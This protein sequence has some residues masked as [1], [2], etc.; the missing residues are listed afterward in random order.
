MNF[1]NQIK[2]NLSSIEYD[3]V[4]YRA[5]FNTINKI[6]IKW[7]LTNIPYISISNW[8]EIFKNKLIKSL[9]LK[10]FNN[11]DIIVHLFIEHLKE[12]NSDNIKIFK[13]VFNTLS[14]YNHLEKQLD[15][16]MKNI[17][18]LKSL[19]SICQ[20]EYEKD[21][22]IRDE[23]I[24]KIILDKKI[25]NITTN[26]SKYEINNI[27][28]TY[29][30]YF[31]TALNF[32]INNKYVL[33]KIV[34]MKK[35]NKQ[36]M[37]KIQ[38]DTESP[39][40]YQYGS[41][42][43]NEISKCIINNDMSI[44]NFINIREYINKF[45]NNRY[46]ISTYGVKIY[47]QYVIQ[48]LI[49]NVIK[50]E[51]LEKSLI[52]YDTGEKSIIYDCVYGSEYDIFK[53]SLDD[54]IFKNYLF[55]NQLIRLRMDNKPIDAVF[56]KSVRMNIRKRIKQE[57]DKDLVCCEWPEI[58]IDKFPNKFVFD[59]FNEIHFD[60][61]KV[62]PENF[63]I[64]TPLFDPKALYLFN[65]YSMSLNDIKYI[66]NNIQEQYDIRVKYPFNVNIR[67]NKYKLHSFVLFE[68]VNRIDYHFVYYKIKYDNIISLVRYDGNVIVV[69]KNQ[70][71]IDYVND[72]Y[73]TLFNNDCL[74]DTL[75]YKIVM[76][77]Y[78]KI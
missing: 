70:S 13:N 50:G 39:F 41:G 72:E 17:N 57:Y 31:K 76:V 6:D 40:K 23:N 45:T 19:K 21:F 7:I 12:M 71:S 54:I 73:N 64:S 33:N 58:D 55:N 77:C 37:K 4:F 67:N 51:L 27:T 26:I 36:K 30:C 3:I 62:F 43:I 35:H 65:N 75:R 9:F 1:F 56:D 14:F 28:T 38:I 49:K 22:D 48:D 11:E 53:Q 46:V 52:T 16:I 18:S 8:N 25:N 47:P 34:L 44:D 63:I 59:L 61:V 15:N 32:V 2:K 42:F 24:N 10:Q 78:R 68:N 29:Q 74:L 60:D 66:V 69:N 5:N 20:I